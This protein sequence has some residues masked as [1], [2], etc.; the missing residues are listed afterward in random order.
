MTHLHIVLDK[1]DNIDSDE[2]RSD[3]MKCA[4]LP[5]PDNRK[6]ID[7]YHTARRLA[8]LFLEQVDK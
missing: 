7:L 2:W 5:I 4:S 8:E 1:N 3:G 6:P